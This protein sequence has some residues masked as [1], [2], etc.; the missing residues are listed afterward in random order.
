VNAYD[1]KGEI[2]FFY[3]REKPAYRML[4]NGEKLANQLGVYGYPAV[5]ITDEQG[6]VIYAQMG[7]NEKEVTKVLEN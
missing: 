7:F 1:D 2:S 5:I 4:Y 6:K 3:K